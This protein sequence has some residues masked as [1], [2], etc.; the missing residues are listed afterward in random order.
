ML[1][2][3]E[4]TIMQYE[5]NRSPHFAR[6]GVADLELEL[7]IHSF[8]LTLKRDD[9]RFIQYGEELEH[10]GNWKGHPAI[11]EAQL[12]FDAQ[13]EKLQKEAATEVEITAAAQGVVDCWFKDG[14]TLDSLRVAVN[15]LAAA[16]L[17]NSFY[18]T[19]TLEP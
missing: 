18:K 19:S 6:T 9:Y 13:Y 5:F 10:A 15:G 7:N 8:L 3:Q 4:G 17:L 1:T 16:I 14:Q 2:E 12:L 11:S